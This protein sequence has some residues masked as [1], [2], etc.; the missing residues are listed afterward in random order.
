MKKGLFRIAVIMLVLFLPACLCVAETAFPP[1][2]EP[3]AATIIRPTPGPTAVPTDTMIDHINNPEQYPGFSFQ[4]GKKLL[5]IWFPNIKDADA[6]VLIYDGEVWMIDCADEK[7]AGK[8]VQLLRQLNIDHIDILFNTHPHHDHIDGLEKTNK[9]AKIGEIRIC[10]PPTAT[11]S[12]L[13]MIQ[14]ALNLKIPVK[15]YKNGDQFSM[16]DGAVSMLILKNNEEW[17]DV[18]NQSAQLRIAYGER[19]ILFT[20]DMEY[21]G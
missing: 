16:G 21:Q 3:P 6:A 13:I 8:T 5:E 18:N 11:Q 17:L 2:P 20:A 19:S 1:S 4:P 10:F 7:N 9:Q 12:G 15:E 14:T